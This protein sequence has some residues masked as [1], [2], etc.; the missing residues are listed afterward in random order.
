MACTYIYDVHR[1][2]KV[3]PSRD[4]FRVCCSSEA[5]PETTPSETNLQS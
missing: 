4:D 1:A 2:V 5:A 3:I